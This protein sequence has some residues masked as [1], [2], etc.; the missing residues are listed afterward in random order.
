V[1]HDPYAGR[2]RDWEEDVISIP[3]E[4]LAFVLCTLVGGGR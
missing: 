4:D 1:R 2:V 3:L